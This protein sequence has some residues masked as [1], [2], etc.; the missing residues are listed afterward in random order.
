MRSS[1]VTYETPARLS[2]L[3]SSFRPDC[4]FHLAARSYPTASLAHPLETFDTNV[5]GTISL[6][7]CLRAAGMKPTVIVACSSAEYGTGC[8]RPI[9]RSKRLTRFI[10][11][12]LRRRRTGSGFARGTVLRELRV[13]AIRIRIFQPL[14]P[15]RR[16]MSVP[17]SK[18]PS[19]SDGEATRRCWRLAISAIA[20]RLWMCAIGAGAAIGG[21]EPRARR[22]FNLGGDDICSVEGI[23]GR[24]SRTG[25]FTFAS[26]SGSS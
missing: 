16:V 21:G 17:I 20:A 7:E 9:Y 6:F 18:R 5:G 10:R 13:P 14:V 25:G 22:G 24:G 12:S 11:A 23:G 2:R 4:I 26:S 19:R 3:L 15:E 8:G 1:G